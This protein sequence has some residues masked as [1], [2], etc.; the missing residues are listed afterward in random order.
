MAKIKKEKLNEVEYYAD[1]Y[2]IILATLAVF[3]IFSLFGNYT[4]IVGRYTAFF[5]SWLFGWGRFLLPFLLLAI[6]GVLLL[7]R[8]IY[9]NDVL[10]GLS[11]IG[12]SL[13][14]QS[15][16]LVPLNKMYA[17][18]YLTKY[19]GFL[20]FILSY[21][22]VYLL[23]PIGA[24][25]ILVGL[26]LIGIVLTVRKPIKEFIRLGRKKPDLKHQIL[27]K[28][29]DLAGGTEATF[30]EE[31]I[32]ITT[33]EKTASLKTLEKPFREE[34][35]E[36][37][38]EA[39]LAPL[40]IIRKEGVEKYL[41]CSR[42]K[43]KKSATEM[44]A[45][46]EKTLRDFGVGASIENVVEGPTVTRFEIQLKPG[47]KVN[48]ILNIEEDIA[49]ALASPDLR[50]LAP[51]PG[52]SAVGIEVPN[53]Y[54]SFVYLGD[55]VRTP[56]FQEASSPLAVAI[57]QE[58]T[59][60]PVVIDLKGLPHLLIAGAT[61]SGKSVC[62]NAIITSILLRARPDQVKFIMIDPKR[63]ELNLYN[64]IPHLIA[65]VVVNPKQAAAALAWA[66]EEMEK[67]FELLSETKTRHLDSYNKEAK[68]KLPYLVI[69]LDELA[70]LMIIAA[71]EV[72]D[73]ICRLAQM[74]RAVGIHLVVATQRPSSDIITGL[75]KANITSR[76][77]FAV[78][79]QVDSRVILDSPGAEKLVGKGDMLFVTPFW[80]KPRRLQG[81]YVSENEIE[82]VVEY[83]KA[84]L[85]P[86]YDFKV[87]EVS[88]LK[89]ITSGEEDTLFNEAA[90]LVI[91]TGK[92]SV[93]YLQRKLKLGYARA[94]RLMD[95]LEERGIVGPAQ[96]SKPREVLLTLSEWEEIKQNQ[97]EM[98]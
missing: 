77:A 91:I 13:L 85:E 7:H 74:G 48:R 16:I 26:F 40:E 42:G 55:L 52:K 76:I 46:L 28:N 54:R 18:T 44:K 90:E 1:V 4:G 64:D 23:K 82:K 75:I 11:L 97:A 98:R 86:Q 53:V 21:P 22:L 62:L 15:H 60:D 3:L 27:T 58:I 84:L 56:N 94:A 69:V 14:A 20:G 89:P 93:T 6:S 61:G 80:L 19:G 66:V 67:R 39:V 32:P 96:G 51:I 73:A 36:P 78:S 43:R 29:A 83:W 92:A 87:V 38:S 88:R 57:G 65:P 10:L 33:E 50:I 35:T 81:V 9:W 8:K 30:M 71:K 59:G 49:L 41:L 24:T 17:P 70:D 5:L 37:L 2:A 68:E 31:T 12:I 45:A 47:V 79:S 63:I 34:K 95:L 25:V 72:E